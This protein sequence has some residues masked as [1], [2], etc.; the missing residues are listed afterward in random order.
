MKWMPTHPSRMVEKAAGI[1]A[2]LA[3]MGCFCRELHI[4]RPDGPM[5]AWDLFPHA[6]LPNAGLISFIPAWEYY[7][8]ADLAIFRSRLLFTSFL[9]YLH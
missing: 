7:E 4:C 2:C 3:G 9:I 8:H 1:P 6:D 5:L